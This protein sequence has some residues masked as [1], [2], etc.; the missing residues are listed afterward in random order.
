MREKYNKNECLSLTAAAE[1]F[2]ISKK[3]LQN[4]IA[5]NPNRFLRVNGQMMV[6]LNYK[7]PLAAEAETLY[8][9]V[10]ELYGTDWRIAKEIARF[11]RNERH[12]TIEK[13]YNYLKY[14]K[15]S[16]LAQ[17]ENIIIAMRHIKVASLMGFAS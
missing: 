7:A 11:E 8:F 1:Y 10:L 2:N 16:R 6:P 9:E 3:T 15:F 14:F 4:A 5:S 13:Y 17:A 12:E